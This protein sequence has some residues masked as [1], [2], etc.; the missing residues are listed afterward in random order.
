MHERGEA[1][2]AIETLKSELQ[3]VHAQ[4]RRAEAQLQRNVELITQQV[5]RHMDSR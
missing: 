2:Q 4:L 1:E 5:H 3:H